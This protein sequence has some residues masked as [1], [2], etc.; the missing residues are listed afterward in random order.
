MSAGGTAATDLYPLGWFRF[1]LT[2]DDGAILVTSGKDND[3]WS[4]KAFDPAPGDRS[5]CEAVLGSRDATNSLLAQLRAGGWG[6]EA[7]AKLFIV[8]SQRS[9]DQECARPRAFLEV[10]AL[11]LLLVVCAGTSGWKWVVLTWSLA[12][13]HLGLLK[14]RT[15]LGPAN[16]INLLRANL[17]ALEKSLGRWAPVF[18]LISDFV[19]GKLARATGTETSFG[20]YA[21][22]FADTAL[23]IWFSVRYETSRTV[24]TAAF[25]AWALP[26]VLVASVS[27]AQG[28][29]ID[30]PRSWW[31]RPAAV[32]QVLLGARMARRWFR[33]THYKRGQETG[34]G[35]LLIQGPRCI[36]LGGTS[37]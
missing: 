26:V 7:W 31:F 1:R 11:H 37:G 3:D 17:P 10:T 21:D 8:A 33:P 20:Q 18:A 24:R 28:R 15:S 13:S 30:V 4:F 23:W 6:V 5:R 27:F 14:E 25:A 19:D 22:F 12:T 2:R 35:S 16:I 36:D 9:V 32:G 29:M 34:D